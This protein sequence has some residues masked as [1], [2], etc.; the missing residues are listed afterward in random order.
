[1]AIDYKV[2]QHRIGRASRWYSQ[3][4]VFTLISQKDIILLERLK[5]KWEINEY[6]EEGKEMIN[7]KMMLQLDRNEKRVVD[8]KQMLMDGQHQVISKDIFRNTG[9]MLNEWQ[10]MSHRFYDPMTFKYNQ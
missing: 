4:I 10:P 3:G 1:M 7:K 8:E 6:S 2:H 5:K 9:N